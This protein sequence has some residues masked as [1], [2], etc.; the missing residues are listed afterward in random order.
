[1]A[2]KV[3][4]KKAEDAFNFSDG[5]FR[6][7]VCVRCTCNGKSV[8]CRRKV[9]ELV[10]DIAV[11]FGAAVSVNGIGDTKQARELKESDCNFKCGI[12]CGTSKKIQNQRLHQQK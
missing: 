12:V 4:C 11:K 5:A 9:T 2:L 6:Y 7:A 3:C 1:M 8:A 10:D